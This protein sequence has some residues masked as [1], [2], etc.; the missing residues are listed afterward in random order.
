LVV[1]VVTILKSLE[2]TGRGAGSAGW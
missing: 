1:K 2:P